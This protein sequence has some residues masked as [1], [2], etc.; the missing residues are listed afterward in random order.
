MM[1]N[2]FET[3]HGWLPDPQ[4]PTL[5]S[6]KAHSGKYSIKVDNTYEYSLT[7]ATALGRLHNSRIKQIKIEAWVFVPS[8]KTPV[9]LVT[10]INQADVKAKPLVWEALDLNEAVKGQYGKWVKV[11]KDITVPAEATFN[12]SLSLYLWRN[13][14]VS[15]PTFLDDIVIRRQP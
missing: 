13:G 10:A 5:T 9:V 11:T 1:S 2:D 14:G 15:G 7:Y 4:N 3:L 12:S 8:P 6:E